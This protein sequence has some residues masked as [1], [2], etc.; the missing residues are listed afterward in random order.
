[1]DKNTIS[2]NMAKDLIPLYSEGLCSEESRLAVEAHLSEC[3]GCRKLL[4]LPI[5]QENEQRIPEKNN[6]FKKLN[7]KMKHSKLCIIALSV[8]LVLIIGA[9]GTLTV[10][11]IVKGEGMISFDTVAQ[12]A[13][14]RKLVGYIADKDFT[15]YV[16][17]VYDNSLRHRTD[18]DADYDNITAKN[19]KELADAYEAAF[20]N[21][22]V[23][24]I[25][26]H[27]CYT[28]S[29]EPNSFI[30]RSDCIIKYDD[31]SVLEIGLMKNYD[32][33]FSASAGLI[34]S[35]NPEAVNTFVNCFNLISASADD[36]DFTNKYILESLFSR[37]QPSETDVLQN[38]GLMT[39][40]KFA[41]EFQ[42]EVKQAVPEF[43]ANNYVTECSF[44]EDRYDE[45]LDRYFIM[46]LTAKDEQ[47]TALLTARIYRRYDGL[48]KPEAVTV[49]R[50]G[51]SDKLALSLEHFFG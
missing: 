4:E 21:T 7:R 6:I 26:I 49:Y 13:E 45:N 42:E 29:D 50:N 11:Q 27:S 44:T 47:G 31:G 20:G 33:R 25:D 23:G 8:I 15:A 1:M 34:R 12:S 3:E 51:C 32:N 9:V 38:L 36:F 28:V 24:S 18:N 14:A 22:A 16:N 35:N 40:I 5:E 46:Y 39:A 48:V 41:P 43:F 17:S 2:C 37:E 10:G 30:V 19:A